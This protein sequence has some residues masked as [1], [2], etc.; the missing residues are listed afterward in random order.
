MTMNQRRTGSWISLAVALLWGVCLSFSSP[1]L[2]QQRED[3]ASVIL[4]APLHEAARQDAPVLATLRAGEAVTVV[5]MSGAYS[6]VK[7]GAGEGWVLSSR[8]QIGDQGSDRLVGLTGMERVVG[9][10]VVV[11]VPGIFDVPAAGVELNETDAAL[12]QSPGDQALA[13]EILSELIVEPV[14][15]PRLGL[16][17]SRSTASA[18]VVCIRY[19]NS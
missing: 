17:L 12:D 4:V 19:A 18:A 13:A 5:Q 10:A 15:L 9:D 14:H 11:A 6:R 2:A 3:P 1:V 16:S 7:S 8:L